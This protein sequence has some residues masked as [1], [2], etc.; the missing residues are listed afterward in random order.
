MDAAL[1]AE[2]HR[3]GGDAGDEVWR[4]FVLNGPHGSGFTW[5]QARDEPPGYV[6][7]ELLQRVV[8]EKAESDSNF[9]EMYIG[10]QAAQPVVAPDPLR[11]ASPAYGG[12]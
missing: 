12:R 11:R 10:D 6:G 3:L 7:V 5:G 2:V 8:A 4:W 1:A 9:S